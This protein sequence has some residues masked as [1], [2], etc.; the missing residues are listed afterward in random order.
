MA[1]G[2]RPIELRGTLADEEAAMRKGKAGSLIAVSVLG[3]ALLGGL[4]FLVG[5]DDKA[6]V[7]GDIGKQIN[8]VKQA[9]FDN[10][11]SCTLQGEDLR[12]VTSNTEL[13]ARLNLLGREGGREFA[14]NLREACRP[15]LENIGPALDTLIVPADM[16]ANVSAMSE[17]AASLRSATTGFIVYLDDPELDY[18]E[19][20]AKPHVQAMVRAWYEFKKAHNEANQVIKSQRDQ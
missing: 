7:Y 12:D 5:G 13:V 11:W 4:F 15:Q 17:A 3:L 1:E 9:S 6:R 8:G 14:K 16:K 2:D 19:E 20:A 18:D 10:F